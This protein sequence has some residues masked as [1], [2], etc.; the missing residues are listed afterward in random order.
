MSVIITDEDDSRYW[1]CLE[2]WDLFPKDT[3]DTNYWLAQHHKM[4]GLTIHQMSFVE[5]LAHPFGGVDAIKRNGFERA[6]KRIE[7][8]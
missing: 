4:C 7:G 8:W 1:R 3:D 5:M 2:C 6:N